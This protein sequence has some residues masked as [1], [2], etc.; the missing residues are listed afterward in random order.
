MTTSKQAAPLIRTKLHRP[1]VA[2][3]LVQRE[4]L[5]AALERSHDQPLTLVSAPAG[6]G[7][8]A[9][10]SNWLARCDLP[11]AWL[12]LDE[13]DSD[14]RVFFS[15]FVAAVHKVFPE[16]CRETLTLLEANQ[17]ASPTLLAEYLS[18]DLEALPKPLVLV[19]DDYHRISEPVI[20]ELLDHLLAHPPDTLHLVILTR[21][22]PPLS[23]GALRAHGMM[24]NLRARELQFTK[25]E[26]A[27]FLKQASGRS[28]EDSA[29][30]LVY[31]TTEG[32]AVGLRLT[33]LALQHGVDIDEFLRGFVGDSG[34]IREYLVEGALSHLP[35][36]VSEWLRKTSIL[37]RFCAPLCE[38]V[39]A[40][41]GNKDEKTLDGQ[42]FIQALAATGLP[43]MALDP[44]SEWHR[45]HHLVQEL[46]QHQLKAWLA[47]EEIVGLHRRTAAWFE[48]QGL[49]EEAIQHTLQGD[50]P[51]AA[52]RL[53]VRHRLEILN[54]EHWFRLDQ[55]LRRLPDELVKKD[56]ELL[57]LKAWRLRNLGRHAEAFLVLDHIE[58]LMIS[59]PS[60]SAASERRRGSVNALRGIQYFF[61]GQA[62]LALKCAEQALIQLPHDCWSERG[63]ALIV[64]AGALRSSGDAKGARKVIYDA[65]ADTSVPMGTFQGRLMMALCFVNWNTADLPEMRLAAKQYLE[66]GK[67]LGLAESVMNARYLL[68]SVQYQQN[69]LSQAETTLVPVVSDRGPP[70]LFYFTESVFVLAAVYQ[71]RGQTDKAR[72]TVES[73][74]E[75]LLGIQNMAM[76][77][78]AQAYQADLALRQ[79]RTAEALK[80]AHGFDPEP[81]QNMFLFHEPRMTLARVLITQGS[82]DNRMQADRL[83]T[84]LETFVAGIHNTR[85]LIEVLALQALLHDAQGDESVACKVLGRAVALAQPG[86]FIRLFV[87]LG[88]RLAGLL[89]RLDLDEEGVRYAR[90]ILAAFGGGQADASDRLGTPLTVNLSEKP[91]PLPEPLTQRELVILSLHT[92]RLKNHEIAER[93]F[94]SAGT[95]KRHNENIYRKLGVHDRSE[96][97]TKAQ[98]LGILKKN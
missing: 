86:G 44:Q 89:S 10:I 77:Q 16:T 58:A 52:G 38:A 65:L 60:G 18:N 97:V 45:Y 46:L 88:P 40:P 62:D 69:E 63:F 22:D 67:K 36:V 33:A 5:H 71:A 43:S 21:R 54:E 27:A 78:R 4:R 17:L 37:E 94:I 29:I 6:Y 42:G 9:L 90:R 15:Y 79:G 34:Q 84:R 75:H 98:A 31:E 35:P 68:G 3:D 82:T 56:L 41:Q 85:F 51:A 20:H 61:E 57:I 50:G 1:R 7:K 14:I 83:L 81:F 64:M 96:A 28:I 25:D 32:W 12:S 11:N 19:L 49:L 72:E 30:S 39:C 48:A 92:E 13:T 59:A 73:V 80:W 74:C 76:L 2:A 26:T 24:S 53:M 93:L 87:D 70:N 66:L 95:V 23:L 91:H 8:T 47:P 55:W